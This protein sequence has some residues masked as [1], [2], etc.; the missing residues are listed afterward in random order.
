MLRTLG[1]GDGVGSKSG[2]S[3]L[4]STGFMAK[5][6]LDY[7]NNGWICAGAFRWRNGQDHTDIRIA[8]GDPRFHSILSIEVRFP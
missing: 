6:R 4:L 2:C 7:P 1:G 8:F 3:E 5:R